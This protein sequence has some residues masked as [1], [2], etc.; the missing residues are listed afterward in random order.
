MSVHVDPTQIVWD[1]F[2]ELEPPKPEWREQFDYWE[3]YV[4]KFFRSNGLDW[5]PADS[6]VEA[7]LMASDRAPFAAMVDA[8][9]PRLAQ[10]APLEETDAILLAHWLPDL[11]LGTSVTNFAMHRLALEDC[12]GLAISDRGLSAPF[13]AF[14]CLVRYLAAGRRRGMLMIADQKHMMYRSDLV[15]RIR[16]ANAACLLAIDLE[17]TDGLRYA[18]YARA[19]IPPAGPGAAIDGLR[20]RLGLSRGVTLIGPAAF[21]GCGVAVDERLVCSAPF[22]ALADVAEPGGEYL[23]LCHDDRHVTALGFGGGS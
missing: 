14:D 6:N 16:P 22:A 9:L 11:H 23:L 2:D 3:D 19:D 13:F 7:W 1:V 17:A 5:D 21:V 15:D 12:F 10:R 20:E 18:G 8:L 4:A